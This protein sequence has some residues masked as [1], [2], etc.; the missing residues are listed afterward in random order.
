VLTVS[1]Y[2]RLGITLWHFGFATTD[3]WW[4]E[5]H[6]GLLRNLT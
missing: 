6:C 5:W 1:G 2:Q 4:H 3:Y